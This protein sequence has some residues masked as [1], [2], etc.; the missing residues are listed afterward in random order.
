MI[1]KTVE[2]LK[3]RWPEAMLLLVLQTAMMLLYEEMMKRWGMGAE[4]PIPAP[5]WAMF[6]LGM[7]SM[8]MII[9]WHLLLLGFVKTAAM[10]G[11]MPQEPMTLLKMGRPYLWRIIGFQFVLAGGVWLLTWAMVSCYY[12]ASGQASGTLP[13]G[14]LLEVVGA[15]AIVLLMKPVFL[16]PAFIVVLDLPVMDSFAR[17]MQVHLREIG[18]FVKAAVIGF[19]IV[20]ALGAVLSFAPD[21]GALFYAAAGLNYLAKSVN[22]LVLL[23]AMAVWTAGVFLPPAPPSGGD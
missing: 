5:E 2:I 1:R 17:M 12:Y 4:S 20:T 23:T 22:L 6:L 18:G 16:V 10:E 15:A 19:G 8:A 3:S 14:W 21:E 7:G 11:T 9:V 13:P